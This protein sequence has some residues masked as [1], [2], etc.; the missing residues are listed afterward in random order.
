MSDIIRLL[1]DSVA[2]QIAAGEVVQRP[3]SAVKELLENAVDAG[4]T[5]IDLV[6]KEAGKMLLQVS[7]NGC[8]MSGTD[9]RMSFER[10]ATSKISKA[11]DLFSIRTMGFRG[12]ALASI[13]AIAHVEMKTR[14]YED[15]LGTLLRVEGSV[16]VSQELCSTA[17]GTCITVKNL[18]FNVPARRNFLKS[19]Q[20]ELRHVL[21][22]FHRVSL[23]RPE[24]GFSLT[25]NEKKLF[26]LQPGTFKQR[27]VSLFGN[28]YNERLLPVTLT[29]DALS[30]EGFIGKAAFARKTRGEQFFF[31][32]KRFI[33]HPYLNHAVEQAFHELLTQDSF[34]TYF[35]HIQIDPS[36]IDINIHP[37]KTEVNFQDARMVYAFVHAA[38]KKSLGQHDLAPKIDFDVPSDLGID[39]GEISR[40]D[41]PVNP[42]TI[43]FNPDYNPFSN[44][45]PGQAPVYRPDRTEKNHRWKLFYEYLTPSPAPTTEL[46]QPTEDLHQVHQSVMQVHGKFLIATVKSGLLLI[47]Q[48]LAHVRV[49]FE[50]YLRQL[51]KHKIAS[52]Q[53]LFPV[54]IHLSAP[55]SEL[56]R[57]M[58]APLKEAGFV[59]ESLGERSFVVT[60]MP[61]GVVQDAA[62]A[63][64]QLLEA[65]KEEKNNL[66]SKKNFIL[67]HYLAKQFAIRY[68]QNLSEDEII[69]L[70][71][72]LFACRMAEIAPDGR[73]ILK[74]LTLDEL[75]TL[76]R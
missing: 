21:D 38:V 43:P 29:T 69:T 12:E 33:R 49:L 42:P 56:L 41:R 60:G 76:L 55:D 54:N 50:K 74:V 16:M 40:S 6:L 27:I 37:T 34:P 72:Q 63:I 53:L 36:E 31:V 1:P 66:L 15:E 11:D 71:N 67:A 17:A 52:Q 7:D 47:D 13:A 24:T 20:A 44:P 65:L 25:H 75:N 48:H 35:L 70:I 64:E 58:S 46:P 30:I 18:F 73:K 57:E 68:G 4:A 28:A 32:N 5:Q 45:K 62:E 8:G 10:H 19:N 14:R 23:I 61:E 59:I 39:F 26:H 2:N 9:A 3:A 51:E 22:E